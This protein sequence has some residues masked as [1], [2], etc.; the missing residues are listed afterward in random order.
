M[1]PNPDTLARLRAQA[2]AYAA[3][4][5]ADAT[6]VVFAERMHRLISAAYVAGADAGYVARLAEEFK[7]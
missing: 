2:D 5:V 4:I 1:T 6:D 7:P 3:D